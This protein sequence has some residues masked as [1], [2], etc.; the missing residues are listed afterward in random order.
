MPFGGHGEVT[1]ET[2]TWDG[3]DCVWV[4][5]PDDSPAG[6][7]GA[8]EALFRGALPALRWTRRSTQV[9]TRARGYLQ[10]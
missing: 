1:Y 2:Q 4:T 3:A 7:E 6:Y 9:L 8:L 5:L 10:G